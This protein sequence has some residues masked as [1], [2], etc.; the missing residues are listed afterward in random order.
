[1]EA[2]VIGLHVARHCMHMGHEAGALNHLSRYFEDR[3]P[4]G[5][6]FVDRS[7][8]NEELVTELFKERR[9]EYV[10]SA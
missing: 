2:S 3:L 4:T 8:T 1:M 5:V 6:Q 7:V 10:V 9:S